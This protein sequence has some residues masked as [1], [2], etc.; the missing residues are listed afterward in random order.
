[1]KDIYFKI[2]SM[3]CDFPKMQLIHE[4]SMGYLPAIYCER[5]N[6]MQ[7]PSHIAKEEEE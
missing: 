6:S 1:M 3:C 5:C 7:G 4:I 2:N